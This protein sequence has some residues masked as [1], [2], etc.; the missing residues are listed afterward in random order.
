MR[1]QRRLPH[2]RACRLHVC[3]PL[4][5]AGAV[6][7]QLRSGL[8][9]GL[10]SLPAQT[11]LQSLPELLPPALP[12][13]APKAARPALLLLGLAFLWVSSSAASSPS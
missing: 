5:R 12:L 9:S 13:L 1:A 2:V 4:A 10:C 7:A 11:G 8:C 3:V 6:A